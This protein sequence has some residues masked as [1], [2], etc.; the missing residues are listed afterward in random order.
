MGH[1]YSP[2]LSCSGET[3]KYWGKIRPKCVAETGKITT[4]CAV[5]PSIP[6]SATVILI[7]SA[8][9]VPCLEGCLTETRG[10]Y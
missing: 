4:L 6:K 5:V 9:K 8:L 7:T 10:A 1:A 3:G 2:K